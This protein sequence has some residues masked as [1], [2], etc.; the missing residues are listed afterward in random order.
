MKTFFT[1]DLHF[2]H[3]LVAGIRGFWLPV[4]RDIL[5]HCGACLNDDH[6]TC[7][8]LT[9][10]A[11]G[12]ACECPHQPDVEAYDE[13]LIANWNKVIEPWADVEVWV[14][15]DLTLRD[16]KL[17]WDKVDR[18]R[19]VKHFLLGNH[20][21]PWPGNRGGHKHYGE[22]L[23]HFETVSLFASLRMEGQQ[24]TLAHCPYTGDR[25]PERESQW[26]LRDVGNPVIHGHTHSKERLSRTERGTLQIH[27]GL[28][29]W[30]LKP[31]HAAVIM[32]ML[33][34]EASGVA[35]A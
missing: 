16:P 29:A 14:L 2:G 17:I 4:D 28:D 24:V 7:Y 35:A 10:L 8:A 27:V 3:R 11:G 20:D 22:Y 26:R 6:T 19:G 31:V 5:R 32:K 12:S 9:R 15:G 1:S 18:L 23:E 25:G 33:R 13:A 30:H 21:R 34:E